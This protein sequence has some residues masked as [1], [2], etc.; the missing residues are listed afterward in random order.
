M[1]EAKYQLLKGYFKELGKVAI[2]FSSGVDSTFL[3]KTAHDV[4]GDNAIALTAKSPAFSS[5]ELEDA[6][7]FCKNEKIRQLVIDIEVLRSP[8]FTEN[9]P[10]RCYI[11]KQLIFKKLIEVAK[12]NG[13]TTIC[14][15]SNIDDDKDYR[16][17]FKAITELGIQSPLRMYH[18]SKKEIRDLSQKLGLNTW[19]KP[20]FACLASRF[21]YGETI[22]RE[23][24]DWVEKSEQLLFEMG[25]KQFRVRIHGTIARIEV[26]PEE[27]P[28]IIEHREKI[29]H[30]LKTIGF[31]Y[32]TLDLLGYRMGSM[33]ANLKNV[34]TQ[35]IS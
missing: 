6:I 32:V 14:E 2:A 20:S 11:C 19:N 25:F 21:V 3:L 5:R 9:P 7:S 33:N 29:V 27:I 18:F 23:K 35:P 8:E 24:L 31:S 26:L 13:I 17:G 10:D 15:G 22:T 4:L 28:M 12:E 30:V 34:T 1:C 16:P